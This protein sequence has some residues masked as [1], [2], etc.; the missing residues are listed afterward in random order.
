MTE[1]L[2]LLVGFQ[3]K[4]YLAD[5]VLQT[6]IMLKGKDDLRAPGGYLHAGVHVAGSLVVLVSAQ[7]NWLTIMGLLVA[8]F[9]AH[10]LLDFA[11]IGYSKNVRF[12]AAPARYWQLH[13]VDQLGHQ[14]TYVV[15]TVLALQR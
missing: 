1:L 14:L 4:H 15:M 13:G 5:Y 6:P 7:T 10:Y 11:K 12:E 3:V 8:E 2:I 9:I